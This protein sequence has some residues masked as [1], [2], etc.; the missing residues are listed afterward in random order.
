M[1]KNLGNNTQA[2][3]AWIKYSQLMEKDPWVY[4]NLAC[5]YNI[6]GKE[7]KALQA[8]EMSFELGFKE[9]NELETDTDLKTVLTNPKY[10]ELKKKY[11]Q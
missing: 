5:V 7:E 6:Q 9:F 4:Y 11:F 2:E 3:Y 1:F 8:L 10:I